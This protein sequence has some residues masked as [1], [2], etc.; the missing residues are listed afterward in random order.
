MSTLLRQHGA[1]RVWTQMQLISYGFSSTKESRGG[2]CC[3]RQTKAQATH[4]NS[5]RAGETPKAGGCPW[6]MQIF[7]LTYWY[8]FAKKL[9]SWQLLRRLII[10]FLNCLL[11]V[12]DWASWRWDM[13]LMFYLLSATCITPSRSPLMTET[14]WWNLRLPSQRTYPNV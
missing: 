13:C 7:F 5:I 11:Q 6:P 10:T 2:F 3:F 1:E 9:C 14:T 4:F 12:C 8:C